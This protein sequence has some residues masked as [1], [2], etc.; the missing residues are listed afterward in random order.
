MSLASTDKP[1]DKNLKDVLNE[2]EA[3]SPN[4]SVLA[5][6]QFQP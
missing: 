5:A 3:Q 4:L 2:I 1:I 6:R